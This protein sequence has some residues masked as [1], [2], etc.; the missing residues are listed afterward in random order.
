MIKIFFLN[1]FLSNI[2]F[3]L[4]L[5]R[6]PTPPRLSPSFP[7]FHTIAIN[8][9]NPLLPFPF[10]LFNGGQQQ[11]RRRRHHH[12]PIPI[13]EALHRSQLR[14]RQRHLGLLRLPRAMLLHQPH[15]RRSRR[16][17]RRGGQ[18]SSSHVPQPR[19]TRRSSPCPA[20]SCCPRWGR[21][22]C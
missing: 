7:H 21:A 11:R 4:N 14:R 1:I 16:R 9:P 12:D 15:H 18:R 5:F 13:R 22:V 20:G 17:R 2:I 3:I 10:S 6:S 8:P 19:E